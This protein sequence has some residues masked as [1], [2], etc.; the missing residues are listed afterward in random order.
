VQS[1]KDT[2]Q[3]LY[4]SG[5]TTALGA[6]NLPRRAIVSVHVHLHVVVV[7]EKVS[8]YLPPC[9]KRRRLGWAKAEPGEMREYIDAG[10]LMR[11]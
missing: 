8:A 5:L 2:S 3:Y 9:R 6:V 11:E 7:H 10:E 4:R 1:V